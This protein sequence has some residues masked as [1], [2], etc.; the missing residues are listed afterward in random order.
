MTPE[1]WLEIMKAAAAS[2]ELL[3][4]LKDNLGSRLHKSYTDAFVRVIQ[5]ATDGLRRGTTPRQPVT[6]AVIQA[7]VEKAL[8][9]LQTVMRTERDED[10]A[11]ALEAL[12]T[13]AKDAE[14]L[15]GCKR[16]AEH[17]EDIVRNAS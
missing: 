1:W 9:A 17:L 4:A 16:A 2:V 12:S 10:A 3:D 14:T 7:D 11:A 13:W 5:D 15:P 8:D 6:A